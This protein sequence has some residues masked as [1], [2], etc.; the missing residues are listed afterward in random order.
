[1]SDIRKLMWVLD[2]P[3]ARV[4]IFGLADAQVPGLAAEP[5]APRLHAL[6]TRLAET[7]DH[8][9]YSS[10]LADDRTNR[11]M[12]V[13]EVRVAFGNDVISDVAQFAASSSDDMA[14]QLAAVLPDFVDAISP[15][16][17]V[18]EASELG[19]LLPAIIAADDQSSGSFGPRLH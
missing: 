14:W 4:V 16:G 11:P 19:L 8:D 12:T 2:D 15:S 6:V 18:I 9:Q 5:G 1:M 17:T 13:E 7:T 3:Q 10:W